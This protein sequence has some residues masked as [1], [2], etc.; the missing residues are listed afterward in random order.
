MFD[1]HE[2]GKMSVTLY[3]DLIRREAPCHMTLSLPCGLIVRDT[4]IFFS[5]RAIRYRLSRLIREY[6]FSDRA[7]LE[8]SVRRALGEISSEKGYITGGKNRK[9][10]NPRGRSRKRK[11][12]ARHEERE[13]HPRRI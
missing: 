6:S 10:S 11:P 8:S 13:L 2:M 4:A 5:G 1:Y 3:H 7:E 12:D 9:D